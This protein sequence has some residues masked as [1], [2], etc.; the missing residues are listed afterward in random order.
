MSSPDLIDPRFSELV[1]ELRA[2]RPAAPE[3]LRARVDALAAS[4]AAPRPA[5]RWSRGRGVMLLA[6][7]GLAA[8][9]AAVVIG[10]VDSGGGGESAAVRQGQVG[11][12]L[13]ATTPAPR[14]PAPQAAAP[15]DNAADKSATAP[16][17][18]AGRAQL[19]AADL[20]LGVNDVSAAT[21]RTLSLTRSLGGYVRTV[22]YGQ[23]AASGRAY[24]EVRVPIGSVQEAIARFSALGKIIEQHVSIQDI[25]SSID[26][27][28]RRLQA[29]RGQIATL[30][31][32]L[33]ASGLTSEEKAALSAKLVRARSELTAVL[34]EQAR[35]QKRAS[36]ATVSLTL[37]KKAAQVVP[38]LKP[39]R[40]DRTLDRIGDVLVVELEILLYVL[41]VVLPL[42]AIL[43]LGLWGRRTGRRRAEQRLLTR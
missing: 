11:S 31:Q 39:S 14:A 35:A 7:V 21:K 29:L 20:T 5:R 12:R 3:E 38:P 18:S 22:D 13:E 32:R 42:A 24:L 27:R 9:A 33:A 36:F 43:G 10:V 41:A 40:F 23:R 8:V 4:E 19:Y 17:A 6:P 16:S 1:N 26:V 30:Q 15:G 34:R 28:F 2:S 25:Q 37:R